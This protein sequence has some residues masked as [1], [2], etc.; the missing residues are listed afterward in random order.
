MNIRTTIEFE[1][2]DAF[3]EKAFAAGAEML[4][5][6]LRSKLDVEGVQQEAIATPKP[7][8]NGDGVINGPKDAESVFG[9]AGAAG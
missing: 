5:D 9:N 8:Y 7:K 2:V 1:D 6:F 3:L 4:A